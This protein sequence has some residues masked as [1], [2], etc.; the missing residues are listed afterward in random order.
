[1]PRQ[2]RILIVDRDDSFLETWRTELGEKFHITS[3][4]TIPD[5]R[6]ILAESPEFAAIVVESFQDGDVLESLPFIQNLRL[7]FQK[8]IIGVAAKH[9]QQQQMV[10]AGCNV[11]ASRRNLADKICEA[12]N[13]SDSLPCL[14]ESNKLK[15]SWKKT[16]PRKQDPAI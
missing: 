2:R 1:M 7:K 5:A 11:Y 14:N 13:I 3:A 10:L 16:H 4:R 9:T 8:P 6:E 12:F 15:R